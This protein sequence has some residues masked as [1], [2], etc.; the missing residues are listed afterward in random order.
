V[1]KKWQNVSTKDYNLSLS[2]QKVH[3]KTFYPT[4][5]THIDSTKGTHLLH[6]RYTSIPHFIHVDPTESTQ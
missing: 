5:S 3:N 2:P 4:L 1:G 6:K